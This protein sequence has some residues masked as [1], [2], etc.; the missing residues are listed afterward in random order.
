MAL[1]LRTERLRIREL[2]RDDE[3][4]LFRLDSDPEVVKY[5]GAQ[6]A[7]DRSVTREGLEGLLWYYERFPGYGIWAL[8]EKVSGRFV[9]WVT[10]KHLIPIRLIQN[11]DED[12]AAI[13]DIEVGFRLMRESWGK[14]Y[15]TE[16]ARA[17]V[18]YGF[19]ELEL[20]EIVGI[21]QPANAASR[22][23]LE[24]VGLTLEGPMKYRDFD[25][26]RYSIRR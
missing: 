24:K 5:I 8:E 4:N 20:K 9:G 1:H 10:L 6:P 15:A 2:T 19:E 11:K 3:E 18:K 13:K 22:R 25:V 21:V 26:L 16:A 14:G 23:V 12:V 7:T 17:V